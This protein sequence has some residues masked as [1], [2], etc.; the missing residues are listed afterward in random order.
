MELLEQLE[1]HVIELLARLD[2]LRAENQ[3][4]RGELSAQSVKSAGLEEENCRLHDSLAREEGRRIE[5][6]QRIDALLHK[7]QE[8]DSVE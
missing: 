7:I 4:L 8:H 2:R 5:A 3:R 1:A 6:L